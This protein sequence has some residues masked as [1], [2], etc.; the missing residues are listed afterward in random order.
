[1][2]I[3]NFRMIKKDERYHKKS[4]FQKT[5]KHSLKISVAPGSV[6]LVYSF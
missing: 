3:I 5:E 4:G 6:G 2:E 1:M